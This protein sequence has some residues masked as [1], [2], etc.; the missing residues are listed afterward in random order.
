MAANSIRLRESE[1]AR[2]KSKLLEDYPP[3]ILLIS[4]SMLRELGCVTRHHQWFDQDHYRYRKCVFL[5]FFDEE[6]ETYFRL[7]YL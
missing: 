1:W 7:R 3:S 6:K 5:D 2:L 4:T